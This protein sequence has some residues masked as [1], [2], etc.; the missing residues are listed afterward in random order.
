MHCKSCEKLI[1]DGLEDLEG[2]E[3]V[4]AR[5][6]DETVEVAFDKKRIGLEAIAKKISSL[7]YSALGKDAKKEDKGFMKNVFYA[8]VPHTGCFAFLAVTVLGITGAAVFLRPLLMNAYFFYLLILFSFVMTTVSIALYLKRNDILSMSGVRRKA[9]YIATMYGITIGVNV[10][11]FF[12]IFPY[13][14]NL[15]SGPTGLALAQEQ[16]YSS[17]TM[18]VNIPCPGHAPLISGDL[19]SIEGVEVVR[20]SLPNNFEVYYDRSKT[21]KQEILNL[22]I[23]ETYPAIVKGENLA[24]EIP[25]ETQKPVKSGCGCGGSSCGGGSG[26]C[27]GG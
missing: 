25:E 1:E 16:G 8:L 2:V 4:D 23:F 12:V 5:F 22:E 20:F 24:S 15:G 9:G 17:L 3:R 18:S 27:C 10:L 7:G 19:K 11:L 6:A 13:T 21:S 14:A 26:S